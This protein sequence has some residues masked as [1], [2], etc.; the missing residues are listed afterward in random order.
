M[1]YLLLHTY[2]FIFIL[3]LLLSKNINSN[4]KLNFYYSLFELRAI[5]CGLNS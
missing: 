1:F 4:M 2:R 3:S 5:A